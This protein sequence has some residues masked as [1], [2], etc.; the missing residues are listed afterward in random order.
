VAIQEFSLPR[1]DYGIVLADPPWP[2]HKWHGR[3]T[4]RVA[5]NHYA[6]MSVV[7]IAALPVSDFVAEDAVLLLWV[8]MPQLPQGLAVIDAWGFQYATAF[9]L[10]GKIAK[11]GDPMV[12]F[13]KYTRSNAEACLLGRRGKGI[14]VNPKCAM[15]NLLLAPRHKH[16]SKPPR[17]YDVINE[18]FG[19]D[20]PRIELFAREHFPGWDVWGMEAP[21][22]N[23][24]LF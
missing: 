15:S 8:T 24:V 4:G 21:E 6:V 3:G 17:Q 19:A 11:N 2:Y 20:V 22:T 10:W 1:H 18:L 14:P 9:L 7:Q 12:G 5:E 13:G 23:T 16:S